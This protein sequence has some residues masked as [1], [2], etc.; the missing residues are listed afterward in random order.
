MKKTTI[1]C[2]ILLAFSMLFTACNGCSKPTPE[3]EPEFTGYNFDEVVINDYDYIASQHEHFEFREAEARFDSVLSVDCENRINYVGTTFQ[4]W[5]K[6]NM[7]FHTPDTARLNGFIAFAESIETEKEWTIDTNDVDYRMHLQF[8]DAV[9]ECGE[10]NA[11]NPISFDSCMKIVEPYRDQLH[12]RALTLRRF[13]D[14]RMPE[15]PQ[16]IFGTGVVIVDVLTGEVG[17]LKDYNDTILESGVKV[18]AD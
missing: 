15:N 1:F 2:S 16:Y 8:N 14:P 3:P 5:D 7:I 13:I 18:I 10:M 12:T 4:C 17:T 11:R 6:V 9:I